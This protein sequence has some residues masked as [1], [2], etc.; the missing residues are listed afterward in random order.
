[1]KLV[2]T[3]VHPFLWE[4]LLKLQSNS[5]FDGFYLVGGTALSLQMG[6]RISEDIDLFTKEKIS[7]DAIL[8]FAKKILVMIM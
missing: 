6:H 3:G 1:M 7:K 8:N 2:K 5:L 4:A